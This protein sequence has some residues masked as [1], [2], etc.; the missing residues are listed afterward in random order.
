MSI[1]HCFAFF[2]SLRIFLNQRGKKMSAGTKDQWTCDPAKTT[3][4]WTSKIIRS[5]TCF[6][7]RTI[8]EACVCVCYIVAAALMRAL[9]HTY[10]LVVCLLAARTCCRAMQLLQPQI[11]VA[12]ATHDTYILAIHRCNCL[13]ARV[14][15]CVCISYCKTTRQS[16]WCLSSRHLHIC[17]CIYIHIYI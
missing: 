6:F 12:V 8:M 2:C 4:H 13:Y 7:H 1:G 9:T 15:V 3:T 17:R 11:L 10:T 5:I 14:C 16:T